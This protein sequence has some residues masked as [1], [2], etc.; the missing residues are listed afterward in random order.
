MEIVNKN[1]TSH[2]NGN[3]KSFK[4]RNYTHQNK[5]IKENTIPIKISNPSSGQKS[6]KNITA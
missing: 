6:K 5:R 3:I 2:T 1:N 4:I